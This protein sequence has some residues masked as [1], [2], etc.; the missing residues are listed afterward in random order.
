MAVYRANASAYVQQV[1]EHPDDLADLFPAFP[2]VGVA[3]APSSEAG[4]SGHNA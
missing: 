3:S 2:V 1:R 4:A